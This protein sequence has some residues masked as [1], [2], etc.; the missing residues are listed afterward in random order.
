MFPPRLTRDEFRNLFTE[1]IYC[2]YIY[3]KMMNPNHHNTI[4][5]KIFVEYA[6]S[7]K[8]LYMYLFIVLIFPFFFS[9]SLTPQIA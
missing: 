2:E 7:V 9:H 5:R 6:M 3:D 4:E 8:D 1:D